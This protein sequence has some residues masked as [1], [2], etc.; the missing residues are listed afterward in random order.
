MR[1]SRLLPLLAVLLAGLLTAAP[2]S[3]GGIVGITGNTLIY[4]GDD[5][6]PNNVTISLADGL[7]RIDEN[8]SRIT[9]GGGGELCTVSG[10]GYRAECP[11]DGIERVD[12]TTGNAGSDVRIRAALPARIQGGA[13][14]DLLIGGPGDDV[15]DGGGGKDVI[16]GG[17][18]GDELTGGPD[19]DL[20]TYVDRI[21]R[22]GALVP[23]KE[24][25]AVIPGQSGTSGARGEQDTIGR[26]FEQIE[27]GDGPDRFE[28]RDGRRQSVACNAGRDTVDL[29]PLDDEAIDCERSEVGPAAGGRMTVPTLVFPFPNREDTARSVVRVRPRLSLQGSAIVVKVRCQYAIG[30]LAADGPGC[31]GVVRMTRGSYLMGQRTIDMPRGRVI[32]WRI[33]LT[34]SRNLARRAGGLPVTVTAVPTRGAGVRRDLLFTVKG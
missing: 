19:D 34:A 9:T 8:A 13:G 32:D 30:L 21:G 7:L 24:G 1:P 12:V 22:G 28:L 3:A 15:I 6:E 14:D 31:R 4:V 2:A 16:G 25:V 11:A 29:D 5:V 23:R 10:D 33:P 26:D 20:L 18:G 27:G 17:E